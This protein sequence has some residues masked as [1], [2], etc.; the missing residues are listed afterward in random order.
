MAIQ[1]YLVGRAAA[2]DM[3]IVLILGLLLQV[4]LIVF[5]Y[6]KGPVLL[7]RERER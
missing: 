4:L 7:Q 5:V 6:C 2:F 3:S 1:I